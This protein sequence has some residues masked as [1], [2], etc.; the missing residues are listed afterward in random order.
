MALFRTVIQTIV[1]AMIPSVM[2]RG[3]DPG[4]ASGAFDTGAFSV[5]FDRYSAAGTEFSAAFDNSFSI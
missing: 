4:S 2:E 3:F 5:A 1:L